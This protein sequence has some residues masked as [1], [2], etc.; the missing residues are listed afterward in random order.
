MQ[1][2]GSILITG[3]SSGIG[4]ALAL[5]Y[6]APGVFLAL[7]GRNEER[8]EQVVAACRAKGALI[9]IAILD[10]S[11]RENM[12]D[13]IGDMDETRPLDLV[14]ANAGISGG[15]GGV[16]SG[17][18][19]DQAR[20]I[21][22]VNIMGVVNT[23]EPVLP[24][25]IERKRGQIALIS[26]L[27]GFRGFPSA[28]A[29]SAS[30]GMVRFYGEALRGSLRSTGV[31]VNVVMPGFVKSRMTDANDFPM[32]FLMEASRAAEIIA[33]GLARDKGRIVFP[34]LLHIGAW[35]GSVLPDWL[36]QKILGKLPAKPQR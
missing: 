22:D 14:I 18:P 10:V 15:T 34:A 26:S 25:M 20:R 27:A 36:A 11:D 30:K 1:N 9:E 21:F 2:P 23:I 4:E 28:P 5:H 13:W 24:R 17:E 32:P 29:Y 19:V 31:S 16:M 7:S 12:R 35:I 3:A 6:A 33:A 8:L